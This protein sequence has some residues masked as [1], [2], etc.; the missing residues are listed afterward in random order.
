MNNHAQTYNNLIQNFGDTLQNTS[1]DTEK[2]HCMTANQITVVNFDAFKDSIV[3]RFGLSESPKSCDALCY[4]NGQFFLIEFKN[5]KMNKHEIRGKIFE[6]L[7]L[8]TEE[9]GVTI[10]YTRNNLTFIL[11]YNDSAQERHFI[12]SALS[13]KA[14]IKEILFGLDSFEEFIL[15][16]FLQ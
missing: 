15:K 8:L 1:M 4:I 10:N 16:K 13:Q 2:N 14:K 9:L 6:S 3:R 7:L 11:V 5:G 12:D